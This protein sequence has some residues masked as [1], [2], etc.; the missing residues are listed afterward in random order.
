MLQRRICY[1]SVHH[2]FVI[3]IFKKC[4]WFFTNLHHYKQITCVGILTAHIFNWTAL[5]SYVE[6][7][8]RVHYIY[9]YIY[10][11]FRFFPFWQRNIGNTIDWV[12]KVTLCSHFPICIY[13]HACNDLQMCLHVCVYVL[14]GVYLRMCKHHIG[15]GDLTVWTCT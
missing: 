3:I 15:M 4:D 12:R 8:M 13:L 7:D 10:S 6:I 2:F 14:M 9:I 5:L 1:T 11:A